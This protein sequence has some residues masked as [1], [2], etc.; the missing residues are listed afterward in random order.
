MTH[1]NATAVKEMLHEIEL[2]VADKPRSERKEMLHAIWSGIDKM[3]FDAQPDP[4]ESALNRKLSA[5]DD[6]RD[7]EKGKQP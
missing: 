3:P 2:L 1:A 5:A 6:R 7:V 4:D